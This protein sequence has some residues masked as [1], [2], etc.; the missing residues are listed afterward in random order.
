MQEQHLFEYAVIRVMPRV[1]RGEF[2]NA[3][4]I[5]YCKSR[6]FLHVMYEVNEQKIKSLCSECDVEAVAAHLKAL[7]LIAAGDKNSGPI[8]QLDIASRFRW[9]TARRSTIIQTSQVHPGF[10]NDPMEMTERLFKQL[11]L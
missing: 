9:L 2:I 7:S 3:G 6:Q 4:I 1:E 11:V 5:L 8:A 10:C